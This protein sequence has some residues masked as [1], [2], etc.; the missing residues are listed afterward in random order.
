MLELTG[1]SI[2]VVNSIY[3]RFSRELVRKETTP[4]SLIP[5]KSKARKW[6]RHQ[7]L[8]KEDCDGEGQAQS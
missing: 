2:V 6:R 5:D 1:T 8:I 7:R 4:S 3:I